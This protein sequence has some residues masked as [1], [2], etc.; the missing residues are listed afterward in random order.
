MN[1][2]VIL[3]L[4]QHDAIAILSKE[5]LILLPGLAYSPLPSVSLLCLNLLVGHLIIESHDVG[6][7][8][9]S[10]IIGLNIWPWNVQ[11]GSQ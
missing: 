2:R 3:N 9:K 5:L 6:Y 8:D 4:V 7:D 11:I 1:T 10:S